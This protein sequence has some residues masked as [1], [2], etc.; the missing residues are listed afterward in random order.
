MAAVPRVPPLGSPTPPCPA[1]ELRLGA[2]APMA[3]PPAA[4]GWAPALGFTAPL[5]PVAGLWCA[6]AG[7][8]ASVGLRGAGRAAAG[9]SRAPAAATDVAAPDRAS[10]S[11]PS[12]AGSSWSLPPPPPASP[13]SASMSSSASCPT[14][15]CRGSP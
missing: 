8:G 1:G 9:G 11:S 5:A 12:W 13:P 10:G 4:L 6:P 2:P 3:V 15:T 7:R 14:S